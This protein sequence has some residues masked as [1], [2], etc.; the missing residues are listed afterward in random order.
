MHNVSFEKIFSL[1]VDTLTLTLRLPRSI[2][3][4]QK[5]KTLHTGML[6]KAIIYKVVNL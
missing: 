4:L 3:M 1:K 5:T 2:N 6:A